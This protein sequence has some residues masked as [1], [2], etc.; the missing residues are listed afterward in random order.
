[1]TQTSINFVRRVEDISLKVL[2]IVCCSILVVA[3]LCVLVVMAIPDY[4]RGKI[5]GE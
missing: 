3:V 1:M 5:R 4:K 2:G